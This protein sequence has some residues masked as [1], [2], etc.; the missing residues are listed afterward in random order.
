MTR[1]HRTSP[2]P[3]PSSTRRRRGSIHNEDL[4]DDL[5][6]I[7]DNYNHRQDD[8]SESDDEP[9]R[10][11]SRKAMGKRPSNDSFTATLGKHV[12]ATQLTPTSAQPLHPERREVYIV[13]EEEDEREPA[14]LASK[15]VS[16][17]A[18]E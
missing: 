17:Y 18:F 7:P 1:R 12:T 3:L 15:K 14:P 13:S 5:R 2:P 8:I 4:D 16:N 9:V 6:T 10:R 11:P